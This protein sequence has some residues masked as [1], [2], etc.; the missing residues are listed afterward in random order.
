MVGVD[1]S[2]LHSDDKGLPGL[3][4]TRA[5]FDVARHRPGVGRP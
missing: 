5:F 3:R 4:N 1:H 2:I